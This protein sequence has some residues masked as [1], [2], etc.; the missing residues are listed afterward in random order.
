MFVPFLIKGLPSSGQT[1]L[2]AQRAIFGERCRKLSRQRLGAASVKAQD[3]DAPELPSTAPRA[4]ERSS[5]STSKNSLVEDAAAKVRSL[6]QVL[7]QIEKTHG[8]GSIMRLG[9]IDRMRVE[10]TP[11]G[12]LTVDVA[13]GG[14]YPRGRLVEIYGPESSGKTTLALHAIAEVQRRGGVA[15]FVDA[16][17]AL[18]PQYAASLGCCTDDL[19]VSQPDTGEMALE[20]VDQLVR[21]AAVDL[22]VVDSV[23]ALVPKAEIEGDMYDN[24]MGLQ[25]RLMSKALRKIAGSMSKSQCTVIF[26]NQLRL[27]V[28]VFYGSPE[29]TSGGNALKY[30]S[31]V[32]IDI[33]R[34]ETLKDNT[35]II[36]K[37]K[38]AKNKVAPPF[39]VASIK[40]L[41]G[42]GIDKFGSLLEAA[43]QAG[44]IVRKGTWYAFNGEH[45][46]HGRAAAEQHL[47]D[48]PD[49]ADQLETLVRDQLSKIPLPRE[50]DED[51]FHSDDFPTPEE[52]M[53]GI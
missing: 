40:I 34:K 37:V 15:A 39:R 7:D 17:H 53:L 52:S 50:F 1:L 42:K 11:S 3:A 29:V 48:N 12:S 41:F 46:A 45:F 30:Y 33:R 36:C 24:Q 13:L 5:A 35:G 20:I 10:T 19:L 27:K 14:G 23:A 28:G 25:A 32:R 8:R 26:L 2:N 49:F 47:K 44:V 18:D 51:G 4:N 16:E 21:S 6:R 43:E 31:T 22:V 9:E 38:I